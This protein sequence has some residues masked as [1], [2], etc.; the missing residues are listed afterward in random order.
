M[1]LAKR[2]F[3]CY[4]TA[5]ERGGGVKSITV[6][7]KS[8]SSLCN[9]RCTYCFYC[10]AAALRSDKSF[11]VMTPETASRM[12]SNVF[13]DILQGDGLTFAFQGGEPTLAGLDFYRF[14][15]S[16]VNRVK[17]DKMKISYA[18]QTNGLAIDEE[19]C[20]FFKTNNFLAGLSIDAYAD[21]HNQNRTDSSGKGT[22]SRVLK[23]KNLLLRYGVDF[24]MLCVLTA[25]AA[26]RAGKIWKFIIRENIRFVQFIPCLS[27]FENI[28]RYA[29]NDKRFF[30]FYDE[31]FPLWK[32]EAESGNFVYV[33]FFADLA[34][35]Y[36]QGKK[37]SCGLGGRC[38]PQLAAESDA[39][40]YPCDFY[41]LDEYRGLSLAENTLREVFENLVQ[42]DFYR[43]KATERE[44][45][46]TCKYF[47]WCA[48]GCKRMI[49]QM[50]GQNCG[51]RLFLDKR[52]NELLLTCK[53]Y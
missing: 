24:N 17:P 49:G 40:V 16:E 48:G 45:C 46:K 5:A 36:L 53:G 52:L 6:M 28:N 38:S 51:L 31:L 44:Y 41:V 32:R 2:E 4:I 21:L 7:I 23:T 50:Y 30:G 9:M 34:S 42:G 39:H 22:F 37:V 14:F 43:E 11:G 35:M 27:P 3:F 47:S 29:L 20:R 12:I 18:F 8:A 1:Q 13:A 19:W 15:V 10:D 33:R 25:E 26:R